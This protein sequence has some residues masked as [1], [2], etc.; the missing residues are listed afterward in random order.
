[1]MGEQPPPAPADVPSTPR[2]RSKALPTLIVLTAVCAGAVLGIFEIANTS[3]GWHVASGRWILEHQSFVHADPF[4]F[5]SEQA[6]WIDHEWLFQVVAAV[7][8]QMGGG[9]A[10]VLLRALA[11]GVLAL[12]LL[13]VGVRSGLSP[14][15]ALL[16]SLLCVVGARPRF[17]LRPELVTLLVAPAACWLYLTRDKRP[18]LHWLAWLA[19][20]MV[21]G[22]NGHGG[23]LVV[24]FLLGGMFAAETRTTTSPP[25]VG[26][27]SHFQRSLRDRSG[28]SFS[29][30]QSLRLAALRGAVQARP[31][32]R[33]TSYS[34]PGV[35]VADIRTNTGAVRRSGSR[36]C[37]DGFARTQPGQVGVVGHGSSAGFSTHSKPGSLF[38]TAPSCGG[39]CTR[40]VACSVP[41]GHVR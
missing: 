8:H 35:V 20:I 39:P 22:A 36:R 16:V 1:M 23:A 5:T 14:P 12:L 28:G 15:A 29:G 34:K 27:E 19:L 40:I 4:S 41:S 2:V 31:P 3:V 30:D 11:V 13:Y 9:P 33:S 25:S 17:F 37:S 26:H 24:P 21:I 38:R 32:C 7:A 10:L 18:S 6:P